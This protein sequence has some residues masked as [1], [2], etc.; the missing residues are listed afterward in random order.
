MNDFRSPA[1]GRTSPSA[2]PPDRGELELRAGIE[3]LEKLL[4]ER[5]GLVNQVADL[6]AKYG[7]WG[8]FEHIRKIE[9]SR[10]KSLVRIEAM[11]DKR[12]LNNDQVDEEAHGHVDYHEFILEATRARAE[13][14]RLES[15]IENI[16]YRV[17]RGQALARFAA[18]EMSLSR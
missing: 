14:F 11:R 1:G 7:S 12:K 6:R 9:I 17:N 18:S 15:Q 8:T 2:F 10:L 4:A 13:Y 3:P 16:D 5:H